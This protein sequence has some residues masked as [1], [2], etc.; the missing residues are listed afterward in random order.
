MDTERF[1]GIFDV[2]LVLLGVLGATETTYFAQV[3]NDQTALKFAI[4]PFIMIIIIWLMK[5]LFKGYITKQKPELWLLLTDWCWQIWSLSL[6]YYMFFFALFQTPNFPMFAL[7]Y[8]IAIGFIIFISILG[9]YYLEYKD[10]VRSY[11]K[12]PKWLIIRTLTAVFF[13]VVVWLIF[14]PLK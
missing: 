9:A 10:E 11:F 13:G 8:S 1:S 3:W 7:S 5:E 14:L 2:A 6:A 12:N 4:Q